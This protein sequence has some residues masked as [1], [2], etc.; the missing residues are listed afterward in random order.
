MGISSR[1]LSF[2]VEPRTIR[3]AGEDVPAEVLGGALKL[4]GELRLDHNLEHG[5]ELVVTVTGP[6]GELLA[7]AMAEV[8]APPSFVPIEEKDV[9]LI[10]Y[11]RV[12]TAKLG[13]VA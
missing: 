11:A 9:G 5:D 13:D 1:Q 7:R 4:K 10:G 3:R 8:A 12:S 6:D 2:D